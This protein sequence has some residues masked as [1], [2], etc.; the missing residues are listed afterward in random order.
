MGVPLTRL[1]LHANQKSP[2]HTPKAHIISFL[3]V[4]NV[5]VHVV[6]C[7]KKNKFTACM[8]DNCGRQYIGPYLL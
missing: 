4:I 5:R 6:H 2:N 1:E 7:V 8:H 3:A